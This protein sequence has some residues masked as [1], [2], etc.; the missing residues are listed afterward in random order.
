MVFVKMRDLSEDDLRLIRWLHPGRLQD[1]RESIGWRQRS[2]SDR[3]SNSLYLQLPR[4]YSTP[5]RETGGV[6]GF[7]CAR[8]SP[9]GRNAQRLLTRSVEAGLLPGS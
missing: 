3:P 7:L 9:W 6:F 4:L 1:Q 5:P 8:P 2:L